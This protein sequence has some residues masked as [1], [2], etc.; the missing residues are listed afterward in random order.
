MAINIRR[1]AERGSNRYERKKDVNASQ[2]VTSL[3]ILCI[4]IRRTTHSI[5]LRPTHMSDIQRHKMKIWVTW[6][7]FRT[8]RIK[9]ISNEFVKMFEVPT[10]KNIIRPG[11]ISISPILWS[12]RGFNCSLSCFSFIL[13][14]K[15][16]KFVRRRTQFF[17]SVHK[18]YHINILDNLLPLCS[19]VWRNNQEIIRIYLTQS[20]S[21]C[22]SQSLG[23]FLQSISTIFGVCCPKKCQ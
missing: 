3:S 7:N 11:I 9:Y 6:P 1:A 2:C 5:W 16:S 23:D 8:F 19:N 4:N 14:L 13:K 21:W 15:L 22:D 20:F 10:I 12:N 18:F 17:V